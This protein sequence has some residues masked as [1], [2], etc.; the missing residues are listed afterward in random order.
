M[1][2]IVDAVIRHQSTKNQPD[3][4]HLSA[5][6]LEPSIPGP[7]EVQIRVQRTGRR[8][9]N[10]TADLYQKGKMNVTTHMVVGTL[11]DINNL[12]IDRATPTILPPHPLAARIPFYTHSALSKYSPKP[13]KLTFRSA[14]ELSADPVV[15]EAQKKKSLG[16][17]IGG[18]DAST[19]TE[20]T[21]EPDKTVRLGLPAV[22]F[23]TDLGRNT[24]GILPKE[25]RPG[26]SWHPTMSFQVEFK[27]KLSTLPDYIAP[28]TFGIWSTGRFIVEGRH[29]LHSEVWTAPSAIGKPGAIA[30]DDPDWRNKMF[31]VARSSQMALSIPIEVNKR[32][33]KGREGVKL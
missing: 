23:L 15:S 31:C 16:G 29:E 21:E 26:E 24:P 10:I 11:P 33:A 5:H 32:K 9:S 18:F 1:A 25:D 2:V 28:Q 3:P 22:A 19:W 7:C 20:L 4:I 14:L 12:K 6:Y 17:L 27:L 30:A 8:Y 13:T